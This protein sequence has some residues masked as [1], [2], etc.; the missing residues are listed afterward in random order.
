MLLGRDSAPVSASAASFV[1]NHL[2]RRERRGSQ[3][4]SWATAQRDGLREP[5]RTSAVLREPRRFKCLV[6]L[7]RRRLR[8]KPLNRRGRGG[9]QRKSWVTPQRDGLREPPRNSAVQMSCRA[10]PAPP[11]LGE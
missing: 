3:R 2:N 11:T 6:A 10:V 9:S 5:P 4:K 1:R 7:L 8:W